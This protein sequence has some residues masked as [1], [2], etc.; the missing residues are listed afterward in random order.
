MFENAAIDIST[1][2]AVDSVFPTGR[3]DPWARESLRIFVDTVAN[4]KDVVYPLSSMAAAAGESD[5]NLPEIFA[6]A[7]KSEWKIIK[8]FQGATADT[9]T[10]SADDVREQFIAFTTWLTDEPDDLLRVR[11]WA[12]MHLEEPR[13]AEAHPRT[14]PAHVTAEFLAT[15][16]AETVAHHFGLTYRQ[17]EY[18]FDVFLR[19]IQYNA[20][21]QASTPYF[22]H[23]L[24]ERLAPSN[25]STRFEQ[26][27]AWSW[28]GYL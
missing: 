14:V 2:H 7:R 11:D 6:S 24:R 8:A 28:G 1:G 17:L 13:I 23:P 26:L 25:G 19:G 18:T 22:A 5:A 4:H 9:I 15:I 27:S 21:C 12:A 3:Q 20:V 10:M 16:P